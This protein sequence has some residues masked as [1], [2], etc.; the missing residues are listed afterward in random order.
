[1]GAVSDKIIIM[2]YDYG[3]KPEPD[4]LVIQ[5]VEMAVRRYR[6]TN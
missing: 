3:P 1:M 6:L 4:Q 2:A 5:A